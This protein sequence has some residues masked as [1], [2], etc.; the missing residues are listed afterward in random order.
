M[1]VVI[2]V[3]QIKVIYSNFRKKQNRKNIQHRDNYYSCPA[4]FPATMFFM[5]TYVCLDTFEIVSYRYFITGVIGSLN[6]STHS[7]DIHHLCMESSDSYCEEC[8][9][10]KRKY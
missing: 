1:T 2:L 8:M 3:I 5:L 7:F 9:K 4:S 10:K 6:S